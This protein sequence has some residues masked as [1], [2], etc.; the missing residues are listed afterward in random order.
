[1]DTIGLELGLLGLGVG[2]RLRSGT[3][4]SKALNDLP[5]CVVVSSTRGTGGVLVG[6]GGGVRTGG[7]GAAAAWRLMCSFAIAF[8]KRSLSAVT[9][10]LKD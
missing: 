6:M 1:M 8:C 3:K 4:R 2:F 10:L 5:S 9:C 7:E